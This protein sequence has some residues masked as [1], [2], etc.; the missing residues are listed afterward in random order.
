MLDVVVHDRMFDRSRQGPDSQRI[1]F[2]RWR[3]DPATRSVQ[4]TVLSEQ[5]QEFPRFDERLTGSPYR[6]AYA[7]GADVTA[8]TSASQPLYR[9]DLKLGRTDSHSYGP[10][11][12]SGEVVFVPRHAGAAED[13]GWLLSYVYDLIENRSAVVILNA[14]DL[15]GEPQ[16]VIELPVRVPLGFHG[17]WIA[18]A[19]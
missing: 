15:G 6:Y 16:A 1:T 7:V 9:H 12:V 13:E 17:N 5:R 8:L 14:D 3:L 18:D 10:H 4:R 19:G 11:H 2:E